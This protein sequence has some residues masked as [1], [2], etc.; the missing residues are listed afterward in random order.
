MRNDRLFIIYII[1]YILN[2]IKLP[3]SGGQST[4]ILPD[5]SFLFGYLRMDFYVPKR[6]P[7][8]FFQYSAWP[9]LKHCRTVVNYVQ[10]DCEA[11][12]RCRLKEG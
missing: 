9:S 1:Y 3:L 2:L 5:G 8:F 12:T 4:N 6:T 10:G 11:Q 7:F